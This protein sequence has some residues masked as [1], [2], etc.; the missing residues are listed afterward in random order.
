MKRRSL[1]QLAALLDVGLDQGPQ[2][3]ELLEQLQALAEPLTRR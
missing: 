3:E 2:A 1:Q